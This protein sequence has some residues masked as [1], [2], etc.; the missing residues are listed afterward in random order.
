MTQTKNKVGHHAGM[1]GEHHQEWW[2]NMGRNLHIYK[3]NIGRLY[4]NDVL[5]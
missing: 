4:L 5:E 2:V 3:S 1:M